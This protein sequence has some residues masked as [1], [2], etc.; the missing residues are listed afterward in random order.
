MTGTNA[1]NPPPPTPD[2]AVPASGTLTVRVRY[3][4]C[5]PMGV[6]HHSVYALWFE[7]GRTELLRGCGVTYADL[8]KAGVFLAVTRLETRFRAPARYDDQLVL[9]TTVTG[10]GRARIDHQYDLRRA[11]PTG[12]G[13]DLLATGAST[14]ACLNTAGRPRALPAW[15]T[16]QAHA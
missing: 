5:D 8:E 2:R 12:A 15:L 9:L 14:I 6:A 3:S 1:Q 11:T 16:A 7:L 13:G 4:E 10:S